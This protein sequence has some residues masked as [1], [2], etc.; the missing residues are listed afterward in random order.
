MKKSWLS[1]EVPD[2]W[3]KE[4]ISPIYKKE[5]KEDPENYRLV[6]FM[7]GKIVEKI[8]LEEMLRHARDEQ[9]I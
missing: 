9:V 8:I 3:K 4:N 5:W 2:D 1:G 6:G 7:S